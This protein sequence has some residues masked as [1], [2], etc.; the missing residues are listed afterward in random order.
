MINDTILQMSNVNLP[1]GG[2]G[3]SGYGRYH[4][5]DGFLAFTNPRSIAHVS[6]LD[7]Y[8]SN[9]RYPPY[10]ESKKS[11]MGKLLKVGFVTYADL[12]KYLLI[13]IVLALLVFV[14]PKL[15]CACN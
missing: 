4:G 14:A 13:L 11:L 8:P 3:A 9:Q 6:S 12:G 1:F 10:T 5:K 15:L 2:V 7:K